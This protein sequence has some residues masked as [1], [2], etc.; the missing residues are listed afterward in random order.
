MEQIT[1]IDKLVEAGKL[2]QDIYIKLSGRQFAVNYEKLIDTSLRIILR[3]I[4]LGRLFIDNL[5]D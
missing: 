4:E 5:P 1:A 3:D 2:G